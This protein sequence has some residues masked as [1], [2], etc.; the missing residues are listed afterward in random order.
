MLQPKE[1][2]SNLKITNLIKSQD[3]KFNKVGAAMFPFTDTCN[4]AYDFFRYTN[5]C[6]LDG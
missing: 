6:N 3:Y 4:Q 1:N 5:L 2:F